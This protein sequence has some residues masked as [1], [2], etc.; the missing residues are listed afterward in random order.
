M[1]LKHQPAG[2]RREMYPT[3]QEMIACLP[4]LASPGALDFTP[5]SKMYKNPPARPFPSRYMIFSSGNFPSSLG[6]RPV[7]PTSAYAYRGRMNTLIRICLTRQPGTRSGEHTREPCLFRRL[8]N[9]GFYQ[10]FPPRGRVQR[11]M[12][13]TR[14]RCQ[15]QRLSLRRDSNP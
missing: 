8:V 13:A 14:F 1:L 3:G 5:E 9:C 4:G 7:L 11:C 15:L 10:Y 2:V 6:I 12:R